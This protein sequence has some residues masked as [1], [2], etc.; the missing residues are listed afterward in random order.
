MRPASSIHRKP[1]ISPLPL[2]LWQPAKTGVASPALPRGRI[3]VT[4]VRTGPSPTT[5]GP[6]PR[7]MVL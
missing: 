2:R 5:K 1:V 4:P 6:S 3:A 7:R